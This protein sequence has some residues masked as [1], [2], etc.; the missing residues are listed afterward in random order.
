MSQ[1]PDALKYADTL[2]QIAA[3]F[4]YP[5]AL[6]L[7]AAELRRLHS[8]EPVQQRQPLSYR[9]IAEATQNFGDVWSDK[10]IGIARAIEAAH[11]IVKP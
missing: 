9:Q 8:G 11:G 3:L 2:E 1:Q 4:S 6:L 5:A 7:A 10:V